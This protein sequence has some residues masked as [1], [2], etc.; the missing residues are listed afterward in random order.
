MEFFDSKPSVGCETANSGDHD[1]ALEGSLTSPSDA[2]LC[3]LLTHSMQRQPLYSLGLDTPKCVQ[4]SDS[5]NGPCL[6]ESTLRRHLSGRC[7]SG[8]SM[9]SKSDKVEEIKDKLLGMLRELKLPYERLPWYTLEKDLKKHGCALVNWPAGVPQARE[10]RNPRPECSG[11]QH[12]I[13]S[14]SVSGRIVSST[15]LSL[16]IDVDCC[17]GSKPHLRRDIGVETPHARGGRFSRSPVEKNQIQGH[18]QQS[19]A[20]TFQ[21]TSG[22]WNGRIISLLVVVRRHPSCL[23]VI[24]IWCGLVVCTIMLTSTTIEPECSSII[25]FTFL[26]S[27]ADVGKFGCSPRPVLPTHLC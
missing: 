21:R 22:G 13:R 11:S 6:G 10:Q 24:I 27:C 8:S 16:P 9:R 20:T 15:H 5:G 19:L 12:S 14:Y 18:D 2:L 7:I 17:T 1:S 25:G 23:R 4:R 3:S 26:R